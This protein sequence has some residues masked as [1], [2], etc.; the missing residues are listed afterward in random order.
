M[1][2]VRRTKSV[3]AVL[4]VFQHT[5][6]AVSVVKLVEDLKELMNKTTV[7]RILDRLE[8]QGTLHSFTGR[9]GLTWYANC[10]NNCTSSHH[11]DMHPHFQCSDCGKTACLEVDIAIPKIPNYKINSAELL[12]VGQCEACLSD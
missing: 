9:D 4:E 10:S 11:T 7:Y 2:V 3:A 6:N 5:N 12:L 8:D 1:G